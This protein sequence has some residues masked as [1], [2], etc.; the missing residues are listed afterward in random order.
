[1]V[2]SL[3][4]TRSSLRQ[5]V[6]GSRLCAIV[7]SLAASFGSAL[8]AHSDDIL[9]AARRQIRVTVREEDLL[10]GYCIIGR[11]RMPPLARG[12]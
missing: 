10:F 4:D 12:Q 9:A 1:M 11:Y 5:V 2:R 8:G 6:R 3:L 7:A